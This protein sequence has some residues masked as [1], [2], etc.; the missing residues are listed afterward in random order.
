MTDRRAGSRSGTKAPRGGGALEALARE[1]ERL[2]GD[3]GRGALAG[4]LA[5]RAPDGIARAAQLIAE[6][7]L[8]GFE[9]ALSSAYQ[10]LARAPAS[11]N[12]GCLAKEA[13]LAALEAGESS[14]AEL[15]AR[16]AM[17]QQ[18]EG[19]RTGARDTA[20]RVRAQGLLGLARLGHPDALVIFGAGL[21]N[22]DPTVR[23]TAAR[24][25]AHRG[26]RDGAGLLLLRLGAGDDQPDVVAEC[27]RG[28]LSLAPDVAAPRARA[29]L[30]SDDPRAR[31]QTLHAL[32]T[33]ASDLAVTLLRDA[34][35]AATLAAP[36]IE[37]I[38]ALGLSLRPAARALL[39][40]LVAGD[41]PSDAEAALAALAIHRYDPRLKDDLTRATA[42]SRPLARRFR[43][44]FDPD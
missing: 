34:L 7:N 38:E 25:I 36:R 18:I 44:L 33:A 24:A 20:A 4:A 19:G 12:P 26:Q 21:A 11:A 32:G 22:R 31:E 37:I 28:L 39:I 30:D 1:P 15:F 42:H 2:A 9:E 3:E 27:L 43:E 16:A 14:S 41:R 29:L 35:A 8:D 17:H 23:L 13:I 10:R 5:G 40:E 6:H